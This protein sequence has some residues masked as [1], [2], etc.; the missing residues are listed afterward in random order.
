MKTINAAATKTFLKLV[1]GLNPG[2]ARKFDNAPGTYMALSVD[3]LSRTKVI[4]GTVEMYALAHR[5]ESNGDLVPDPDVEF[6]VFR[7]DAN[8]DVKVK[9]TAIEHVGRY[10]RYVHFRNEGAEA[11]FPSHINRRGQADLAVFC[12]TWM[13]NVKFQQDL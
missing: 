6:F 3:C 7:P 2:E 9:P 13:R 11:P 1:E 10:F 5:Y 12:G 8:N 4:G